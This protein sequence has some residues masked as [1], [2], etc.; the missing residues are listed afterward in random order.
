M[1]HSLLWRHSFADGRCYSSNYAVLY[2]FGISITRRFRK[3]VGPL[4]C[5]IVFNTNKNTYSSFIII[6]RTIICTSSER[7]WYPLQE[8]EAIF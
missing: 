2:T 5:P 4:V 6:T 3:S 8:N 1:S 7:A